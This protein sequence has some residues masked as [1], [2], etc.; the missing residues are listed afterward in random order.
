MEW[1]I[2][3][4]CEAAIN[5]LIESFA[6][7]PILESGRRLLTERRVGQIGALKIDL[8]SNEH[9]PPHFRVSCQ[10]E[11]ANYCISDCSKING[12]L[13]RFGRNIRQW[14]TK[15]K[16]KLI[17]AW[18]SCRPTDCPVGCYTE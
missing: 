11:S 7:G 14:H 4:K 6:Q 9:P 3:F 12:G 18:N 8:F 15:N 5:D 16:Q 13:E 10:G 17:S 2:S 1:V